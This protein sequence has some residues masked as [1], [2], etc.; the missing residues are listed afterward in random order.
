M[1]L[2]CTHDLEDVD[3]TWYPIQ[4]MVAGWDLYG[5]ALALVSV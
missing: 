5:T 2:I 1:S 4:C 3:H